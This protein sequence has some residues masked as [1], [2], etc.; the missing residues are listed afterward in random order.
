MLLPLFSRRLLSG[1]DISKSPCL[2]IHVL[3]LLGGEADTSQIKG[4]LITIRVIKYRSNGELRKPLSR[5]A[6][7]REDDPFS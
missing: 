5:R 7:G 6:E 4:G 3:F 2:L 1:G